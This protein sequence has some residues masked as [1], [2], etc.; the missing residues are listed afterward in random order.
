MLLVAQA[1]AV[2]QGII[3]QL[4]IPADDRARRACL[5]QQAFD[6]IQKVDKALSLFGELSERM[7]TQVLRVAASLS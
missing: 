1:Q 3:D 5:H 7:L 2:P 6:A 4:V